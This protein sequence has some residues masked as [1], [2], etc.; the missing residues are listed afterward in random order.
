LFVDFGNGGVR[1]SEAAHLRD[2]SLGGASFTLEQELGI[3]DEVSLRI[4][5]SGKG[6]FNEMVRFD[7]QNGK[8]N[9]RLSGKVV[10]IDQSAH[11]RGKSFLAAVEFSGPMRITRESD[12]SGKTADGQ[13][14]RAQERNVSHSEVDRFLARPAGSSMDQRVFQEERG[15]EREV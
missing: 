1:Y 3:G 12:C 13:E 2:I 10:R 15:Y 4:C 5:D 9:I 11:G 7:A 8:A 14:T 6:V